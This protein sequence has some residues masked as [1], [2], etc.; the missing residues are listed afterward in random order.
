MKMVRIKLERKP[1]LEVPLLEAGKAGI[2]AEGDDHHSE[3]AQALWE[4]P[5]IILTLTERGLDLKKSTLDNKRSKVSSRLFRQSNAIDDTMYSRKNWVTVEEQ[6]AHIDHTFNQLDLVQEECHDL[7][8]TSEKI[9][10]DEWFEEIDE[11]TC[12]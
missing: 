2:V 1:M 7:L 3:M 5:R 10:D 8:D 12:L 9:D 11:S 6:L 4:H